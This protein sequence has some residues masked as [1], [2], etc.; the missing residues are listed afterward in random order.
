M[1]APMIAWFITFILAA[2]LIG[3]TFILAISFLTKAHYFWAGLL[4]IVGVGEVIIIEHDMN[5]E[6]QYEY[7]MKHKPDC[8]DETVDCLSSKAAWY[9]DSAIVSIGAASRDTTKL[10]DSLKTVVSKYERKDT[11]DV[12]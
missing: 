3:A 7:L 6:K 12:H 10:I 9:K 2:I 8:T 1:S 5:Y 11:N 4:I